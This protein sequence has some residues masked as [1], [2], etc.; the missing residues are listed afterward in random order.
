M[1]F[2]KMKVGKRLAVGFGA[3]LLLL[4]T[5]AVASELT[6][7]SIAADTT[8]LLEQ[9]LQTERLVTEWKGIIEANVQRAQAAAKTSDPETQKFFEDG[10]ARASQRVAGAQEQIGKLL[11]DPRAK[12]LF[13]KALENRAIY[14]GHRKAAF[15]AKAQGDIEQANAIIAQKFV[16]AGDVYVGSI[17][18][19]ADRQKAAIDEIGNSIQKRSEAAVITI[20][21]L[22]VASIAVALM[23]GW[24]ITRSLLTQLGGEPGYAAGITDRIA[25]ELGQQRAGD[26]P[27]QH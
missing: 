23:L 5:I 19:L 20:L 11:I 15:S 2:S 17:E 6:I 9:Q 4:L 8:N 14:Q 24:L 10:I 26:Q 18:A 7:R 16:P 12:E 3:A 27:A 22:S 21:I 1:I 25:A 13:A